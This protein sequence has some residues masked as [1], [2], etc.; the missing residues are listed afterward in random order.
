[1]TDIAVLGKESAALV[2]DHHGKFNWGAVIAGAIAVPAVTFFFS[3]LGIGVGLSYSAAHSSSGTGF[4]T[5]AAIYFFASQAFG[6]TVGGYLVGRLI[7]PE[8]ET[9]REEEFRAAAHGFVMWALTA[10]VTGLVV[11]FAATFSPVEDG[12][13]SDDALKAAFHLWT[14]LAL[15]FGAVVSVASAISSRWMDDKVG[16]S[17]ARRI[18]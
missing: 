1:M 15:F 8:V 3:T 12:A 14:A 18:K 7:G 10:V 5:L 13:R 11:G 17:M 2:T 9:T 16:F 6:F 4:L